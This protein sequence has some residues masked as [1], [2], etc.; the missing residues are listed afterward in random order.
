MNEYLKFARDVA[1]QAGSLLLDGF[2]RDITIEKKGEVNLVTEMD[3][4]AERMIHSAIEK[5]YPSHSIL[6]EEETDVH[7]DSQFRWIVDPLDGTTNYAHR[8]P[9]WCVSMALEQEGEISVGVI[10]NPILDE[11]FHAVKGEGAFCNKRQIRVSDET[12]LSEAVLATGFPYDI[13]ESN[14]DNLDNFARF[15]K[16][17]RAI[18]RA[19]SAALDMAYTA[20]GIFDGFWELKLSAW[21]TAAGKLLVEEAGAKTADFSGG[22]FDIFTGEVVCANEKLLEQMIELL[23]VKD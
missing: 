23:Q 8:F 13:R 10:Y 6:A 20:S 5:K 1:H 22:E 14:V 21:D 4:K 19:G 15:Y 16:K 12:E 2:A 7:H 9:V 17:C 3:L 11:M 18:R